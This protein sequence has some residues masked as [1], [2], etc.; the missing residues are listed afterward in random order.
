MSERPFIGTVASSSNILH[1]VVTD[2]SI[3]S[4]GSI[5]KDD[6]VSYSGRSVLKWQSLSGFLFDG[7]VCA[8]TT[9]A[10]S[11][12]RTVN[13]LNGNQKLVVK[14]DRRDFT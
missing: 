12:C 11:K 5:V 8:G 14:S 9:A 3:H 4:F 10:T 2:R 7:V 13:H 1:S 6:A